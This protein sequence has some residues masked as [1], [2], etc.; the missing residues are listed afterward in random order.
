MAKSLI[1]LF[2]CVILPRLVM[3]WTAV[4]KNDLSR[5]RI[6]P[7][8]QAEVSLSELSA[9]VQ[10]RLLS[11]TLEIQVPG[12]GAARE[13]PEENMMKMQAKKKPLKINL[14]LL[15]WRAKREKKR[16]KQS[17]ARRIWQ[18]CIDLDKDDGR[19]WL[20]L[21]RDADRNLHDPNLAFQYL[22]ECLRHTPSNVHVRQAYG[23]LLERQGKRMA[24]MQQYEIALR[25]DPNHAAS[26]VAKAR[27]LDR[28]FRL[29]RSS[30][31]NASLNHKKKIDA[32]YETARTC[33]AAA[34]SAAPNNEH[35]L[36][37][38]ATFES[39]FGRISQARALFQRAAKANPRNAATYVAWAQLEERVIFD[40]DQE[41]DSFS[42]RNRTQHAIFQ[43]RR[44]YDQA[45]RAHPSNT[46]A[47][48]AWARFELKRANNAT[49]ALRLL[50]Q[51]SRVRSGGKRGGGYRGG[52]VDAI[53]FASLGEIYW[54]NLKDFDQARTAFRRG[55]AVDSTHPRSYLSWANMEAKQGNL[56]QARELIQQ[57]IWGATNGVIDKPA[58]AELWRAAARFAAA[59]HDTPEKTRDAFRHALELCVA[60][61]ELSD[62]P[63]HAERVFLEWHDYE[64][65]LPPNLSRASS[66]LNDAA[67][68]LPAQASLWKALATSSR[69]GNDFI[70]SSYSDKNN[71]IS[72]SPSS[73]SRYPNSRSASSVNS[74]A[75]P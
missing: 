73:S 18:M 12:P 51:A 53:V 4:V 36:L 45:L 47:L 24:A 40:H 29:G 9:K 57:G 35:A 38:A 65:S 64:R 54:H 48:T 59:Q 28:K 60:P 74:P 22:T 72:G 27:L 66:V 62:R 41:K 69:H 50:R 11:Q 3:G 43:A 75:A 1:P 20:A 16:G 56:N 58:L 31:K 37:S 63:H 34:L 42:A 10:N 5:R 26:W 67:N 30:L 25:H 23:V 33:Y 17:S 15:N 2:L 68:T 13:L 39:N 21:S 8:L 49:G 32:D 14:D 46:R 70:S 6:R 61:A 7:I 55:I 44:L 19:A 52:C 71:I